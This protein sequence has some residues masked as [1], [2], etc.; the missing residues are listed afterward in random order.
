MQSEKRPAQAVLALLEAIKTQHVQVIELTHPMDEGSPY[1]PAGRDRSPF[2]AKVMVN[3][4]LRPSFARDLTLAEHFGTH[5]DAPAHALRGGRTVDQLPVAQFLS[6]AGVVDVWEAVEA[7]PDY[8]VSVADIERHGKRHGALP[9]GGSVFFYTGWANRWPSQERYIHEDEQGVKH[10]P[11]VSEE[12]AHYLVE[13]VRPVGIGIDTAS[14]EGGLAKDMVVHRVLLGADVYILENVANLEQL[15]PTGAAVV[16][17]PLRLTG[18]SGSPARI[19]ALAP[20]P[21][22]PAAS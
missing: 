12:A 15:P 5:L 22:A 3:F 17:L 20:S 16:A 7:N 14:I 2:T 19:L 1:W 21:A 11:G 8:L 10:F 6:A 13:Q 18:G 4:D 9:S